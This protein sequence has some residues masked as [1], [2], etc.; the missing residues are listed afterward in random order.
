VRLGK[1]PLFNLIAELQPVEWLKMKPKGNSLET[2]SQAQLP[3]IRNEGSGLSSI[4]HLCRW[5]ILI[6]YYIIANVGILTTAKGN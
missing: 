2:G 4:M 1:S 6:W 5:N 3:L